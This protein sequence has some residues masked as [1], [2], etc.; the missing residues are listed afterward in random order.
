MVPGFTEEHAVILAEWIYDNYKFESLECVEVVLQN[1]PPTLDEQGRVENNWRL[2]PDRIQKWMAVQLEKEAIK[3]E[4]ENEKF[5]QMH[6]EPLS[7]VDYE[8][9]AK[10]YEEGKALQDPV[11]AT[12]FNDPKYLEYK[13]DRMRKEVL[14]NPPP[15]P[16]ENE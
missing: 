7:V 5:K 3:R 6:A 9:F 2:T 16:E 11:K 1:P 4:K 14:N 13:A 12:G 10:R 8:S 15:K